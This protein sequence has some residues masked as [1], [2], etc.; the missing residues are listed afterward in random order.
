MCSVKMCHLR[1]VLCSLAMQ[2]DPS[3][4]QT[5][6]ISILFFSFLSLAK[7]HYGREKCAA[8]ES[9]TS[10]SGSAP[11]LLPDPREALLCP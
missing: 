8:K 7:E 10:V 6:Q 3:L 2:T 4:P 5:A 1:C 9:E 11:L